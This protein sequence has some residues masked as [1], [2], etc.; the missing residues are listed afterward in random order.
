[1]IQTFSE[2]A[3]YFK[4]KNNNNLVQ[5][6]LRKHIIDKG[7]KFLNNLSVK[8]FFFE[9]NEFNTSSPLPDTTKHYLLKS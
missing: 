1:M 5:K 4:K 9:E 2:V 3:S 7:K 8:G 6:N